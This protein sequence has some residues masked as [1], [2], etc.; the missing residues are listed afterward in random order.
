MVLGPVLHYEA[1]A[2]VSSGGESARA[3]KPDL[4]SIRVFVGPLSVGSIKPSVV[5]VDGATGGVAVVGA[6][7]DTR[8]HLGQ[9]VKKITCYIGV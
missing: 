9:L 7:K 1:V 6:G 3:P 4:L 2:F 5:R 8:V